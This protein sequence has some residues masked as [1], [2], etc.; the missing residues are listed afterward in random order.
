MSVTD[1]SAYT[2]AKEVPLKTTN[3]FMKADFMLIK[4]NAITSQ[5]ED[6]ILIENKLSKGTAYT[7]RQ[8]E[9]FAKIKSAPEPT[10]SNPNPTIEMEIEQTFDNTLGLNP[11]NKLNISRN[12]CLKISD[13]RTDNISSLGLGDIDFIDFTKF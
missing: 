3:G 10:P 2:L 6:V 9:G 5:I 7:A 8:K 12:K 13:H 4:K 1:L 11:P